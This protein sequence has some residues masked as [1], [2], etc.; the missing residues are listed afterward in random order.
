MNSVNELVENIGW[1]QSLQI[2]ESVITYPVSN[3]DEKF[4][5]EYYMLTTPKPDWL[6]YQKLEY[7]TT[8]EL[9][10]YCIMDLLSK[11]NEPFEIFSEFQFKWCGI[12]I[13]KAYFH[14]EKKTNRVVCLDMKDF[15]T[16]LFEYT[17]KQKCILL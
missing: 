6:R 9:P 1:K 2:L 12:G 14:E 15:Q 17:Q 5:F 4:E 16:K 13:L 10:L 3:D 11:S 8:H 7:I